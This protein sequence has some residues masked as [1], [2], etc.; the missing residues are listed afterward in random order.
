[1]KTLQELI[2]LG[3]THLSVTN[4]EATAVNPYDETQ[5]QSAYHKRRH[6]DIYILPPLPTSGIPNGPV[7]ID[8]VEEV[9]QYKSMV[10][11]KWVIAQMA[12]EDYPVETR[13]ALRYKQQEEVSDTDLRLLKIT[14]RKIDDDLEEMFGEEQQEEV[15]PEGE[16]LKSRIEKILDF[17]TGQDGVLYN[18]ETVVGEIEA[19]LITP[20]EA[21]PVASAGRNNESKRLFG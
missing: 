15:K 17:N 10:G 14:V 11:D 1:M 7:G 21:E 12:R 8:E 4:E 13:L 2:A 16:S 18:T 6:H 9:L 3:V 20:P 19:L 5:N